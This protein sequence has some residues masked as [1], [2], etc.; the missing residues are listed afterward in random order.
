VLVHCL[1]ER[2]ACETQTRGH[3]VGIGSKELGDV[4]GWQLLELTQEKH[5]AFHL[6]ER[7]QEGANEVECL[8]SLA[9][10]FGARLRAGE[11]ERHGFFRAAA[12]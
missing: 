3:G 12:A 9:S 8:V 4:S 10:F 11:L 6:V 1:L 2:R 7:A 5:F